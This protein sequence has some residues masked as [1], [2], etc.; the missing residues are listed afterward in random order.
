MICSSY[1]IYKTRAPF[2][3]DL[4]SSLSK[5][6]REVPLFAKILIK[7]LTKKVFA[8]LYNIAI[9]DCYYL[10]KLNLVGFSLVL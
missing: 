3:W 4:T 1:R 2:W 6:F 10:N 8:M 5:E 9:K 7:K